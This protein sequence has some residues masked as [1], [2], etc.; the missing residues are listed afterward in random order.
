MQSVYIP[1]PKPLR[2]NRISSCATIAS[3]P[4]GPNLCTSKDAHAPLRRSRSMLVRSLRSNLNSR[5]GSRSHQAAGQRT[6]L[7]HPVHVRHQR[8][9]VHVDRSR[10]KPPFSRLH[11]PPRAGVG[12]RSA[13]H[14]RPGPHA[15]QNGRPRCHA[16]RG[17][18]GNLRG[19]RRQSHVEEPRRCRLRTLHGSC[20]LHRAG[21]HLRL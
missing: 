17:R 20:L 12:A 15:I 1:A 11:P 6:G 3:S 2:H 10:W 21:R 7:H 5:S 4:P 18:G 13:R 14:P 9:G 16:A 19:H 8:Q